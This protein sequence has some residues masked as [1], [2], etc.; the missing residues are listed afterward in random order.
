MRKLLGQFRIQ[1]HQIVITSMFLVYAITITIIVTSIP[2]ILLLLP[3]TMELDHTNE[4]IIIPALVF[5]QNQNNETL[6]RQLLKNLVLLQ[7]V[8][9]QQ[10][11]LLTEHSI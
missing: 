2:G 6:Q 7:R 5:G 10:S 8:F 3:S 1:N 4:M 9:R 11:I